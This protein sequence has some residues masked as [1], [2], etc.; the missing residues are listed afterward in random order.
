MS[1]IVALSAAALL[2]VMPFA[3]EHRA[4]IS[5]DAGVIS[6]A[7]PETIVDALKSFGFG[8]ILDVD[9]DG[10]PMVFSKAAGTIFSIR[11][12][13]CQDNSNCKDIQFN[14]GYDLPEGISAQMIEKWNATKLVGPALR[15]QENDPFLKYFVSGVDGMTV[16]SFE[17][18]VYRWEEAM[19]GFQKHIFE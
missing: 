19:D 4:S 18:V 16:K 14:S 10:D 1:T 12:Y 2:A 15:D 11:F 6:A 3:S 8:A 9:S 7:K 5:P 17:R 13:G